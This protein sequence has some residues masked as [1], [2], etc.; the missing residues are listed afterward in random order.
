MQCGRMLT[1]EDRCLNPPQRN[2]LVQA[3]DAPLTDPDG[4]TRQVILPLCA[5]HDWLD[6]PRPAP[7]SDWLEV[8]Q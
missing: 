2:H 1:G 5:V 4:E 8:E 6:I 3:L 7:N